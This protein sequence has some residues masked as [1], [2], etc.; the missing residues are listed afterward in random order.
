MSAAQW[1]WEGGGDPLLFVENL[2]T[3]HIVCE[4]QATNCKLQIIGI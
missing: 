1:G 2:S 3:L 4:V